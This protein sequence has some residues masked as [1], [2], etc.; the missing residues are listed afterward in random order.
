MQICGSSFLKEMEPHT[1]KVCILYPEFDAQ[2]L[3][4]RECFVPLCNLLRKIS[5]W[6]VITEDVVSQILQC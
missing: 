4:V 2:G 1:L 3:I 5:T 6:K